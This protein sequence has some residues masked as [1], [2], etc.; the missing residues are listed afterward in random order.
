MHLRSEQNQWEKIVTGGV[1][2]HE[3]YKK[4]LI[5]NTYGFSHH[6]ITPIWHVKKWCAIKCFSVLSIISIHIYKCVCVCARTNLH[7]LICIKRVKGMSP[8]LLF[9][10]LV[11]LIR[12]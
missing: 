10:I 8:V 4:S 5:A 12:K 3:K 2:Y 6:I 1:I 11:Q 7:A 9:F